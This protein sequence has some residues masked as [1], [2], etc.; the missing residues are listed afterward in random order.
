[1]LRGGAFY[2]YSHKRSLFFCI[3][4][5]GKRRGGRVRGEL[6]YA[7]IQLENNKTNLHA[8]CL[9]SS[10]GSRHALCCS[11]DHPWHPSF[12]KPSLGQRIDRRLLSISHLR[13][14]LQALQGLRA[15]LSSSYQILS[16][17]LPPEL[18][19]SSKLPECWSGFT[20]GCDRDCTLMCTLDWLT[21]GLKQGPEL[22]FPL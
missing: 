6:L 4:G 5:H 1:M 8:R 14:S 3:K 22:S 19:P 15:A 9:S 17:Q 21:L 16:S 10:A 7:F 2:F 18:L 11:R 20:T 12:L 13:T